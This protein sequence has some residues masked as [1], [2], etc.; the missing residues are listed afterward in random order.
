[1]PSTTTWNVL[2]TFIYTG[3]QLAANPMLSISRDDDEPWTFHH[4]ACR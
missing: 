1:M 2:C 3:E 4:R